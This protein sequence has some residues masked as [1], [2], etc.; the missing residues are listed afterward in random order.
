MEGGYSTLNDILS[1]YRQLLSLYIA[2]NKTIHMNA[3]Q[4]FKVTLW[5]LRDLKQ[6]QFELCYT[7]N[8]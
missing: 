7:E 8:E 2:Y 3:N 1:K 4:S 6:A 5:A